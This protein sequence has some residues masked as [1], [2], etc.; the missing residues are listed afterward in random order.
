MTN[1]MTSD[2][3][4][5]ELQM[6]TW[7]QDMECV[8]FFVYKHFTYFMHFIQVVHNYFV[9]QTELKTL[10]WFTNVSV[11]QFFFGLSLVHMLIRAYVWCLHV[12][13]VI[14]KFPLGTLVSSP[15]PKTRL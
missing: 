11:P 12:L 8:T 14:W 7:M 3:N 15:C 10:I 13:P 2:H 4:T 1:D 5:E 6:V 9:G